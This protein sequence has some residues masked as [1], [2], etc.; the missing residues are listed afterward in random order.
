MLVG[1]LPPLI[2]LEAAARPDVPWRWLWAIVLILLV[3]TLLWRRSY[4]LPMLAVA[5]AF[6]TVISMWSGG[7][8]ELFSTAYFLV[9]VYALMRWASGR[10]MLIGAA[11]L[12]AGVL[13]SFVSGTPTAGDAI[14]GMAV[15]V[16]MSTLGITFR[17]RASARAREFESMRLLEREQL[18]RD[19]H[20]TVA[21]HVS[22]IAIQAQA[23]TAV[24]SETQPQRQKYFG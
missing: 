9:L 17:W 23:G 21:H 2:L 20:D 18:A 11:I 14:G 12:L 10:A 15:L 19:L 7:E 8:P 5:F 24:A 13:L 4:P 22:A 16:T 6:G 1:V 3:P